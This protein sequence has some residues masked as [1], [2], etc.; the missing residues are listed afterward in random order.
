MACEQGVGCLLAPPA[1]SA[2]RFSA[3]NMLHLC[4]AAQPDHSTRPTSCLPSLPNPSPIAPPLSP[5]SSAPGLCL[6]SNHSSYLQASSILASVSSDF[7][8]AFFLLSGMY[9]RPPHPPK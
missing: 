9:H 1:F 3:Q 7:S 5:S 4:A 6:K 8:G 2:P